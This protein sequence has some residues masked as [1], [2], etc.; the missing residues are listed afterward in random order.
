MRPLPSEKPAFVFEGSFD[1]VITH[2][3][4]GFVGGG[5]CTR[6]ASC[7]EAVLSRDAA[8]AGDLRLELTSSVRHR[9]SYAQ[10]ITLYDCLNS[11]MSL[12][13]DQCYRAMGGN[14]DAM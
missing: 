12:Y 14:F 4:I 5:S 2:H 3:L 13:P 1:H 6:G 10:V 7:G 9:V 8:M 11:A